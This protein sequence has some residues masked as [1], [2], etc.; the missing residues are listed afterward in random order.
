MQSVK[1]F[2]SMLTPPESIYHMQVDKLNYPVNIKQHF[3]T[4][5]LLLKQWAH[6]VA[7]VTLIEA[8]YWPYQ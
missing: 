8:T 5:M 4:I 1:T 2:E 3:S 6:E 7:T